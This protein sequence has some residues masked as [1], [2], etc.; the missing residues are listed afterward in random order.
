MPQTV[1]FRLADSVPANVVSMWLEELTAHPRAEREQKIRKLIGA[2][3]DTGYG[4]CHLRDPRIG[5]MVEAA[6]LFF[7]CQ[8]YYLHAW[9]IMPNH[10]HALFT[11]APG[12]ELSAIL[13]SWKSFTAKEANKVLE[14]T[15]R[16]WHEDYFDRYVRNAEHFAL[17]VDYIERNPVKAGLCGAAGDWP[18][19]SARFGS[20]AD[21][22][23]TAA[24][25]G[26]T[27]EPA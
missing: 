8:R 16:F 20:V 27:H 3:L 18:F 2:Y 6:L 5:A 1:T 15:G 19:G 9:V 25:P 17:S 21:A 14:R 24:V 22:A 11:S 12:W 10:V 13:G 23:G 4:A 26:R 7:D